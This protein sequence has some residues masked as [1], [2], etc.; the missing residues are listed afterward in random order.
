MAYDGPVIP[1]TAYCSFYDIL[2]TVAMTTDKKLTKHI[3]LYCCWKRRGALHN[4]YGAHM[5]NAVVICTTLTSHWC[6]KVSGI[7]QTTD[8]TYSVG[9]HPQKHRR[10]E[11]NLQNARGPQG[12]TS[13][14]RMGSNSGNTFS[15]IKNVTFCL[16]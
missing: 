14:V 10:E 5:T 13:P 15:D 12:K 7:E 2:V 1:I 11:G 4:I 9:M 16:R 3:L 6:L 8:C